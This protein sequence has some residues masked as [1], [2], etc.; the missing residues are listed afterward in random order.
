MRV[1]DLPIILNYEKLYP[2]K[3][4]KL[5]RSLFICLAAFFVLITALNA[6]IT[7]TS[8]NIRFDA[9]GDGVAEAVL[10]QSGLGIGAATS[11]SNLFVN[12]NAIVS[13]SLRVGGASAMVSSLN[14]NGSIGFSTQ[15]ISDNV[16]LSGNSFVFVDNSSGN[17]YLT[18]PQASTVAERRYCIKATGAVGTI[19]IKGGDDAIDNSMEV[20]LQASASSLPCVTL[21][22]TG[23]AWMIVDRTGQ[24]TSSSDNLIG[25][26]KL[27]TSTED[28]SPNANSLTAMGS[29][30][31]VAG[32]TTSAK[33]GQ[34]LVF[35]G[36]NDYLTVNDPADGSLDI[37]FDDFSFTAWIYKYSASNAAILSKYNTTSVPYIYM[38][39]ADTNDL[40]IHLY[41]GTTKI[42]TKSVA[43]VINVG[44][45]HHVATTVDRDQSDG[46]KL[47]VDGQEVSYSNQDDPST[48]GDL[49]NAYHFYIGMMFTTTFPFHGVIDDVRYFNK[50]LQSAEIQQIY[51]GGL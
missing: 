3:T 11:G 34:G 43:G 46:L 24:L 40:R 37:G 38:L 17:I 36:V 30:F 35:D 4:M 45:W 33:L 44:Q 25:W 29:G 47:Y 12:G 1:D 51:R 13:E 16:T 8:G 5:K 19:N 20:V 23:N 27:N 50:A 42:S 21:Q 49:D 26:W 2:M 48:Q 41:D 28:S 7:S 14:I 9:D 6:D 32:N 31:S 18:L 22:S 10:N 15:N 39:S